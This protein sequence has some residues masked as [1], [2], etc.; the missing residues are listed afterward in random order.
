EVGMGGRL[1][2][3]NVVLPLVSVITNVSMDHEAY[4]GNTLDLVA[5]EKAGII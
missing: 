3:T 5:M 2:A 1:D 4:L